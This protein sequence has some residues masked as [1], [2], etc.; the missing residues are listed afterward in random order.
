MIMGVNLLGGPDGAMA[1]ASRADVLVGEAVYQFMY[2]LAPNTPHGPQFA[3]AS[4]YSYHIFTPLPLALGAGGRA[5]KS[6][7]PDHEIKRLIAIVTRVE[8]LSLCALVCS[9][10]PF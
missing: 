2:Q 9:S 1:P 8:F 7:R 5:F 6:P 3:R 10:E 4:A